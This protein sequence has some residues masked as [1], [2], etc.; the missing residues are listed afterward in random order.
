[1]G[2]RDPNK[3]FSFEFDEQGTNMISEQIM[4]SYNSGF[5][6]DEKNADEGDDFFS[7]EG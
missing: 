3:H 2:M 1:M 4:D 7:A 6:D 5:I